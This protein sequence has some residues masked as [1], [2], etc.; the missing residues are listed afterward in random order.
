[1]R[2]PKVLVAYKA[3]ADVIGKAVTLFVTVAAARALP[4]GDFGV[5]ALAMTTGWI[6]GVASDA[7]LPL[8]L[9]R[10][11]ARVDGAAERIVRDV[12]RLRVQLAIA[13]ACVGAAIA[14]Y[15]A[16]AGYVLAFGF[17]VLAY[18]T[19]AVL[20]TLAHVYR[21]LGR[22]DVESTL[23]IVTRLSTAVLVTTVLV[24][25]PT[26]LLLSIASL[27]PPAVALLVSWVIARR[28]TGAASAFTE[29]TADTEAAPS[30]LAPSG[31]SFRQFTTDAAPIGAGVLLSAI[32]FRC[33]V[34]FVSYW[35]GLEIVGMYNAVFRL[36][37]GLR[38]LPAAALAVAFPALCRAADARP[39]RRLA[40][41][42]TAAGLFTMAGTY[43]AAPSIV[44]TIYG[45]TYLPAVPALRVLAMALPL[46]FLN[47]ALTHQV[48][49]WDGQ[50]AYAA[51]TA[52]A[53]VANVTGNLWLIPAQGMVG[54]AWS[55]LLTELVVT[56]GCL[57]AL[58]EKGP[59]PFFARIVEEKGR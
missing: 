59:G 17:V 44:E 43:I 19:G 31:F 18:L 41:I 23:T 1:M 2:Q 54:A 57:L 14:A 48:I 36:V 10:A 4:T 33:D 24:V 30:G 50:R 29:A 45:A 35:H 5:L 9:A 3:T 12:M 34:Y 56:S 8:Y 52:V 47:Y 16:P 58:R 27:I 46:F 13:A 53:L 15:W 42:L 55:T 7:G 11:V 20:D 51:I 37:E 49:A 26:L 40:A 32:Y 25:R 39:L 21:G 38:L 22:T 6:L 28:L